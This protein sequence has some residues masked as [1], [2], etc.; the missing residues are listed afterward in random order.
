MENIMMGMV[1]TVGAVTILA[2]LAMLS[3]TVGVALSRHF[4]GGIAQ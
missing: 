2:A 3:Y 4:K 1:F